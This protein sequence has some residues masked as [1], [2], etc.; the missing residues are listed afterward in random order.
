MNEIIKFDQYFFSILNGVLT[1]EWLDWIMP[2]WRNKYFWIPFY[3]LGLVFLFRKFGRRAFIWVF[4]LL[5]VV[6]LADQVSS[7]II[8][9][10]FKRER[11]CND[12]TLKNKI[13]VLV[14]CGGGYSFTSSHATNHFAVAVFVGL[15]FRGIL[16]Y[17]II[18]ALS[19]GYGQIYVGAHFPLDVIVGSIMGAI[20]GYLV[21]LIYRLFPPFQLIEGKE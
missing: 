20:L 18:W 21:F 19:I 12:Q 3:L 13:R 17:L 16:G 10:S 4:W 1:S 11:P 7:S 6:G 9:P 8:K 14:P 15:T 2:Y 5:M